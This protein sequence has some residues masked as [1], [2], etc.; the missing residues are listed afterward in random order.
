MIILDREVVVYLEESY[1]AQAEK[2]HRL[3]YKLLQTIDNALL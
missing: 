3:H 2:V 1:L